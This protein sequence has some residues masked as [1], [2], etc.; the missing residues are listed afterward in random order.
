MNINKS[1]SNRTP[2][3]KG[4]IREGGIYVGII[5]DSKDA[6][7]MGRL[8]VWI[9]ELGG[10]QNDRRYWIT[11]SYVSPFAGTTPIDD[12]VSNGVN[13]SDS[14][15][16]YGFWMVP[17]DT[18]NMVIVCFANGDTSRG[19]WLGCVY[20]Q[21]MNHMVPGVSV[22]KATTATPGTLPPVVEYNKNSKQNPNDPLRPV[23]TP[24]HNG[25][26]NQGLYS[27]Q[28]RGP[29]SSSARREAPSKV[30]GWLTPRGNN[31]HVDDNPDNEFIRMRT[32]SGAQ[33]MISE[34][35][36]FVYIN[37]K[38]GNSW[39]EISDSGID[40]YSSESVSI[41]SEKDANV[42]A[43]GNILFDAGGDISMKAGGKI[44]T[45]SGGDT[46]M[47]MGGMFNAQSG[48]D[49][50]ITPGGKFST[51]AGGDILLRAEGSN[52]RVGTFI[53]DNSQPIPA[54][55]GVTVP[56]QKKQYDVKS[57][58]RTSTQS[59]V[60]RM[61]SHEP[62]T[63]H[64]KN[65]K[66]VSPPRG[67]QV[68]PVDPENIK[69]IESRGGNPISSSVTSET[70]TRKIVTGTGVTVEKSYTDN[71]P[72]K[73]IGPAKISNNVLSSIREASDET[74][75]SFGYM[76]AM[77]E[78]ESSFDPNARA[79][80][81]SATGLYQFTDSTWSSMVNKYGDQY[82]IGIDDR[83]DPR[84]N[85]IM[86]GLFAK[87]NQT[88]LEVNGHDVQNTDLYMAHF[89]GPGGANQ[90]LNALE[91]NGNQPAYQAVSAGA[92]QANKSIFY[93]AKNGNRP[94]TLQEVYSNFQKKIEPKT[95]VYTPY[96]NDSDA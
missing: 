1:P 95:V 16:S 19:Y 69:Q 57:G 56:S 39:V 86:G 8:D 14:Q 91:K 74:G 78:V 35:T 68:V 50:L 9:P 53:G 89:L 11:V 20:P 62:W 40:I 5:K 29:S 37:S 41:R 55:S 51:T 45:Q 7:R 71:S 49:T 47:K 67:V 13:M 43:D 24:L 87:E 81:S 3:A 36:G 88:Y 61:P 63:G 48:G 42:H 21:F 27:D 34:T 66:A 46:L 84:A 26:V 33:I 15:Q 4:R 65:G 31:I 12:T 44:T 28:E 94:R 85:A 38:K 30:F 83:K 54:N 52:L 73:N 18:G 93:D 10:D 25:L 77:A 72:K 80:T 92:A 64:P 22:N 76:M 60:N 6:Q 23:F 70:S 82:N 59:I 2:G 32:R 96:Y 17:P 90:F 75:V 79:G 58:E